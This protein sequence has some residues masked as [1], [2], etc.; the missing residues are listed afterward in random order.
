MFVSLVQ[1]RLNFPGNQQASVASGEGACADVKKQSGGATNAQLLT[2]KNAA[3][4]SL[5]VC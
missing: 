3:E 2:D 4:E 1:A 5:L